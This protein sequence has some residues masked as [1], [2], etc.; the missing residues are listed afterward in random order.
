MKKTLSFVVLAC[1]VCVPA[2]AATEAAKPATEPVKVDV[3]K[4]EAP[5]PVV[6]TPKPADAP[7]TLPVVNVTSSA[8]VEVVVDADMDTDAIPVPATPTIDDVKKVE[9]LAEQT[10][11]G[12]G[13]YGGLIVLVLAGILAALKLRKKEPKA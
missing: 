7:A 2:F 13:T 3:A 6:E 12:W 5:K 11:A 4:P 1:F 10:G 9:T 8:V